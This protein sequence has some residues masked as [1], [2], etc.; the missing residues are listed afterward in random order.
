MKKLLLLSFVLCALMGCESNSDEDQSSD[1]TP[2]LAPTV[3][4]KWLYDVTANL[5]NT[6]YE[7]RDGTR[8]TYYSDRRF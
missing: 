1:E 4:G 5:P 2:L 8:Y 3:E 7:F 6:M